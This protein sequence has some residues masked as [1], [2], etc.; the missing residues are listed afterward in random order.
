[1]GETLHSY[2]ECDSFISEKMLMMNLWFTPD[3][4]RQESSEK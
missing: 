4:K 2:Y 3:T 1:M